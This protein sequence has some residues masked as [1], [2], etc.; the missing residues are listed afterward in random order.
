MDGWVGGR[1]DG[2]VE[3]WPELTMDRELELQGAAQR[4][5]I[6]GGT[7]MMKDGWMGGRKE[8]WVGGSLARADRE[9]GTGATG[10]S[11]MEGNYRRGKDGKGWKDGWMDCTVPETS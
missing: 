11:T 3:A 5:E 6:S 9:Q 2:W 10:G 4:K 8:G 1:R 7:K